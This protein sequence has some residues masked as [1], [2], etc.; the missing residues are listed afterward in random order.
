MTMFHDHL[1]KICLS[2]FPTTQQVN[3]NPNPPNP[4]KQLRFRNSWE[5]LVHRWSSGTSKRASSN[6]RSNTRST[7]SPS[8]ATPMLVKCRES[9][10]L[11]SPVKRHTWRSV[12]TPVKL[13]DFS[14]I[15]RGYDPSYIYPFI[16]K[17]IYRGTLVQHTI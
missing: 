8:S 9:E 5:K 17:A 3:R 1:G 15:Y 4:S 14:T 10:R 16:Y 11:G 13:I 7:V 6:C 2:F 12:I